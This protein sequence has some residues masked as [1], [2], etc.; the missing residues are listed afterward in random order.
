[1]YSNG[2]LFGENEILFIFVVK[3]KTKENYKG[4]KMDISL[5]KEGLFVM[6]IGMGTVFVFLTVM[7]LIMNLNSIFM[8]KVVNRFFPEEQPAEK[9]SQNN[10]E[11][12]ALAIACAYAKSL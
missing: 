4:E 8:Q 12:I 2:A 7:I 9:K 10:D 1:M 11:E 5:L 3:L 6:I